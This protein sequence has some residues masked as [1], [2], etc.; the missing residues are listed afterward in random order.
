MCGTLNTRTNFCVSHFAKKM[1]F[2]KTIH[3][4][5]VS[6]NKNENE[7]FEIPTVMTMKSPFSK[8]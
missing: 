6:A 4:N 7:R 1:N 8:V 2:G 3:P 5:T